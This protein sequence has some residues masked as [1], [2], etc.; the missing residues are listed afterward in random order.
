MGVPD[1]E[2]AQPR[3]GVEIINKNSPNSASKTDEIEGIFLYNDF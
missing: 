3:L 1:K 2:P